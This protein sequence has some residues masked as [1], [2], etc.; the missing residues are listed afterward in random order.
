MWGKPPVGKAVRGLA[1]QCRRYDAKRPCRW[2]NP[3]GPCHLRGDGNF[4]RLLQKTA[5]LREP[6]QRSAYPSIIPGKFSG[7]GDSNGRLNR[8]Y[9]CLIVKHSRKKIRQSL[10]GGLLDSAHP[11]RKTSWPV[12][13]N[14]VSYRHPWSIHRC[15]VARPFLIQSNICAASC[16]ADGC[17]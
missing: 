14:L 7:Q 13:S 5:V 2:G 9:F 15:F 16:V 3:H 11:G 8:N 10:G 12:P 1:A 4:Q 17:D 6:G